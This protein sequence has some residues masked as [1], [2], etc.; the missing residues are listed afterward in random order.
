MISRRNFLKG[1]AAVTGVTAACAADEYQPAPKRQTD[2][3]MN[4]IVIMSDEH[5]SNI[6]G[7]YGNK[8]VK[9][10]NIDSLASRG[11]KFNNFYCNS[12]LCVPSRLVFTSGK[13]VSR[14]GAWSNA[15]KL[16]GDDYPSIAS[17]FNA[18]GYES[19]LCG[20]MHY[21]SEH[22]YGFTELGT[23]FTN[24]KPKKGVLFRR[25]PDD[26]SESYGDKVRFEEFYA[27]DKSKVLE[28][29]N[30]VAELTVD[31]IKNRPDDSKPF[32][33]VAG[34]LAPHYPLIV[35]QNYW[36]TYKD[37]IP[38][39]NIPDGRIDNLPVNY[40]QLRMGFGMCDVPA[41]TVKKGRELYYGLVQWMDERVGMILSA[42]KQTGLDENTVVIY[43]SDHGE[44]MG[45]NGLWWKNVMYDTA[46]KV[47]LVISYPKRWKGGQTKDKCASMV[48]LVQTIADLGGVKVPDDWDG[49]SMSGWLDD[50]SDWKDYA[51][52]EYYAHNVSTGYVMFRAGK[53]KY[54][55]HTAFDK[56]NPETRELYNMIDDPYETDN[57]ASKSDFA[58]IVSQMHTR[59]VE[60]L[61]EEPQK[62]EARALTDFQSAAAK[63]GKTNDIAVYLVAGQSN[64]A[65][66]AEI[67]EVSDKSVLSSSTILYYHS[68]YWSQGKSGVP[69]ATLN[70]ENSKSGRFGPEISF[71]REIQKLCPMEKI[72]IIKHAAGGTDLAEK[73]NPGKDE[74]DS[75]NFGVEYKTFIRTVANSIESLVG[76]GYRPVI[77]GMIWQQGERD[78][79]NKDYSERY[80][81]NLNHFINRVR[82]QF[83]S[84]DMIFVYGQVL[85]YQLSRFGYRD[86]VR[87]AQAL[88]D[89]T[90]QGEYSVK[91]AYMVATDGLGMRDDKLHINTDGQ[92]ELGRL[93][94]EKIYSSLN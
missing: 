57:L 47:P 22:R 42:L 45:E 29:D 67:S 7:C 92:I 73:W 76:L 65:G 89:E 44:N 32:F 9:T 59:M 83:D 79:T 54:V 86:V 81:H 69:L 33:M 16:A 36:D 60:E 3:R 20:K 61:G 40:K 48:D 37:K 58:G 4:I 31:F 17:M 23:S 6:L 27:G 34:F 35:P 28:H 21:A 68:D 87:E 11:V 43:T 53:Y 38:M 80:A 55:Y 85:P 63:M 72:A 1:I 93:F 74:S 64:A 49:T 12:P 25:H 15:N 8:I 62:T 19:Y 94:A 71:G 78:A 30:E 82:G 91:R 77:K 51:V 70:A 84:P 2:K 90:S 50:Q 26:I 18:A 41:E 5:N 10:P 88:I 13:Y 24:A 52:S 66:Q 14:T 75:D 46:S 56:D 39:P